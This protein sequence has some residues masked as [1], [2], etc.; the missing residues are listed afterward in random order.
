MSVASEPHW[1]QT[2]ETKPGRYLLISD[3]T[4]I[5]RYSHQATT[6]L[7]MLGDGKGRGVQLHN[8]LVYN[9][10]DNL[11]EGMAG[12]KLHYRS[13]APKNETRMER[14]RRVRESQ[15]WGD[16]VTEVGSAPE[17]AQWI[18][19]FDRGG[20]NFEAMCRIRQTDC[21]WIIRAAKLGRN[22][23]DEQ[24]ERRPL[25]EVIQDAK[26]LGSYNLNLRSRQGVKARTAHIDVSVVRVTLP[27]PQHRSPW[28]RQCE[29]K[30]LTM[31]VVI[32]KETNAPKGV[33]PV[34]WVLLTSLPVKTFDDAWQIISDY[35]N[36]WL[37]MFEARTTKSEADRHDGL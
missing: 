8:C 15:L 1:R 18:H 22:V 23:I 37:V 31:N 26:Y 21:D 29:I 16:L 13:F 34:C 9:C 12:A 35:E 5:N 28:L 4:D 3:T 19:V 11:I 10:D 14:L 2:R 20:D 32:V 6:G 36:R 30:Q 7:G 33:S 24:Q 27:Q 17:G 25:S